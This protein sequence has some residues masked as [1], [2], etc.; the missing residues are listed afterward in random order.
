MVERPLGQ[1]T[2]PPLSTF[3]QGLG[4]AG[5]GWMELIG[6]YRPHTRVIYGVCKGSLTASLWKY[7]LCVASTPTLK[8]F[9]LPARVPSPP[10]RP[11]LSFEERLACACPDRKSSLRVCQ[12][13]RKRGGGGGDATTQGFVCMEA[14]ARKLLRPDPPDSIDFVRRVASL[15]LC[16]AQVAHQTAYCS[17]GGASQY[18]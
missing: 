7:L 11:S 14:Q 10:S 5:P 8:A 6:L 17:E 9:F 1:S 15:L 16:G 12:R 3:L 18:L 4:S 2:A 13:T